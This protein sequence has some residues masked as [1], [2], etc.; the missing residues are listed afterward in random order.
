LNISLSPSADLLELRDPTVEVAK[1]SD[2]GKNEELEVDVFVTE[3]KPTPAD[4]VIPIFPVPVM[5][6]FGG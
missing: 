4:I 2:L 5:K 6:C 3:S 1:T